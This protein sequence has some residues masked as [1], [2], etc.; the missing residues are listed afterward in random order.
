MFSDETLNCRLSVPLA[1]VGRVSHPDAPK[2]IASGK[3][4]HNPSSRAPTAH[5]ARRSARHYRAV[6]P[7]GDQPKGNRVQWRRACVALRLRR[8][9]CTESSAPRYTVRTA[10]LPSSSS[11]THPTRA[12]MVGRQHREPRLT[13]DMFHHLFLIPNMSNWAGSPGDFKFVF[14]CLI[15]QHVACKHQL[16]QDEHHSSFCHGMWVNVTQWVHCR[17]L[18]RIIQNGNHFVCKM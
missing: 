10:T 2:K 15:A 16:S 11:T 5:G 13:L 4:R 12:R 1:L 8:I 14:R 17:Y 7:G 6:Q 18:Q 9:V 3:A